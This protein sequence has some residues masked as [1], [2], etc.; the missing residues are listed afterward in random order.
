L[1]PLAA[2]TKRSSKEHGGERID[3]T[4]NDEKSWGIKTEARV[5]EARRGARKVEIQQQ[6]S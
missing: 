4:I 3:Q 6:S 1:I 2:E 5:I